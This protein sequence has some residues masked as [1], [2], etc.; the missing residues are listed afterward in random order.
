[1]Q[2][3]EASE[4]DRVTTAVKQVLGKTVSNNATG[5]H[6]GAFLTAEVKTLGHVILMQP[7]AGLCRLI[8]TG[9]NQLQLYLKVMEDRCCTIAD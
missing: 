7:F 4:I 1:M 2:T 8:I 9:K 5:L 3:G 6:L